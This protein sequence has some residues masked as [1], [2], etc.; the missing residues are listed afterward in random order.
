MEEG[1]KRRRLV[2]RLRLPRRAAILPEELVVEI[3][4][5]LPVKHVMQLRWMDR[6]WQR[7]KA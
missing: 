3:I 6:Y 4:S 2:V 5:W 1:M 7:I